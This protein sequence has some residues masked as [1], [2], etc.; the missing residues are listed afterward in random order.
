M[1]GT[2]LSSISYVISCA[3]PDLKLK[4]IMNFIDT[5]REFLHVVAG[6]L[7][8]PVLIALLLLAALTLVA[9]G[10]FAR[11][12]WSRRGNRRPWQQITGSAL[13]AA[14][15]DNASR[16]PL[17]VRLERVLQDSERRRWSALALL[18]QG[19]RVGPALG[20][21][22]TLIPM[23][24]ALQGLAEGNLPS[25]ASNMVTAFAA[26]VIGLA[27]SVTIYL[28]TTMREQWIREDNQALAFRAEA[29]LQAGEASATP[30]LD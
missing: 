13:E 22:G 4:M 26:T 24:N 28:I 7:V 6:V 3:L 8:W 23:A 30:R 17:D 12:W 14:A 5:I 18:R 25:L 19:V 2:S 21:M 15:A 1:L 16:D 9:L 10:D 29:L 11:E 27:I 20:L